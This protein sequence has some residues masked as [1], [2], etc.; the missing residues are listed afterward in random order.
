L[1][2]SAF[3]VLLSLK[4][5]NNTTFQNALNGGNRGDLKWRRSFFIPLAHAT[6][7]DHDDMLPPKIIE[8]ED[9]S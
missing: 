7:I 5:L 1:K 6:S 8:G 9:L 2:G 3:Y 4:L